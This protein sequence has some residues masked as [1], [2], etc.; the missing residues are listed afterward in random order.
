M[1]RPCAGLFQALPRPDTQDLHTIV[2]IGKGATCASGDA[3]KF[4]K[5]LHES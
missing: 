3:T 2:E 5:V 1:Q 4:N